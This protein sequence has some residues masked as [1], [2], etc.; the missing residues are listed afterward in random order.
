MPAGGRLAIGQSLPMGR[1]R[2]PVRIPLKFVTKFRHV[3]RHWAYADT[4]SA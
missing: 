1:D 2:V 3:V 4:L